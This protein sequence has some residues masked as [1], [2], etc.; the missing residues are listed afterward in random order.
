MKN[1]LKILRFCSILFSVIVFATSCNQKEIL[2][3]DNKIGFDTIYVTNNYHIDN[4]S[5]KPSC[6]LKLTYIYPKIYENVSILDS[7]QHIF[8]SGFLD[9]TYAYDSPQ[10]AV[11]KYTNTYIENYKRDFDVFYNEKI[12]IDESDKYFSYYEN[13]TNKIIFDKDNI[14]TFQVLQTN[15]KGGADSYQLVKNYVIDL[16]TGIQITESDI[17]N[18]GYEEALTPIFKDYILKNNQVKTMGELD[19]LGYFGVDEIIPNGNILV[20][21]KGITYT[22]NKG[23]YSAYKLDPITITI[24]YA[25]LSLLVKEGSPISKFVDK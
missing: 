3:V 5:T 4:D 23:E 6:N 17:F 7:I 11:K 1:I 2:S 20:D 14:I 19:N 13:I 9:E 24:P 12:K 18:V 16:N 15:Y 22:F 21:N 10:E 25:E 8:N